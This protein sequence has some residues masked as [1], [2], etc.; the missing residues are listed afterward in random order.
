MSKPAAG[1]GPVV[2]VTDSTASL[3]PQAVAEHGLVVVPLQVVIG[4]QVLDEGSEGATPDRVAQ[5]LR[6]YTPVSTSRPSPAVMLEAYEKAHAAGASAV[7]S[8]HLSGEMSGTYESAQLAAREAPLPVVCV[9]TRQVGIGTGYA[10][11]AAARVAAAGGSAQ[12]AAPRPPPRCSTSTPSSTCAAAGASARPRRCS[13]VRWRSSRCCAS[14]T[15]GS[16]PWS[17]CAP[18][19]GRWPGSRS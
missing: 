17:G 3:P 15:G 14:T 6:E 2:V 11:L 4:A 7:V 5:A 9:D 13:G 19:P 1:E 10:A 16:T 12:E 8:V 18:P